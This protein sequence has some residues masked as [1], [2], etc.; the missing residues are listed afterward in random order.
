M[1]RHGDNDDDRLTTALQFQ[2][3]TPDV[4]R[5]ANRPRKTSRRR[6]SASRLHEADGVRSHAVVLENQLL[7]Q[8][9]VRDRDALLLDAKYVSLPVGHTLARANDR[10]AT[11]YF[12][13]CGVISLVSEMSTGHQVAVAA[14][15]A[16]GVIGLGPL[17][18]T[19]QYPHALVVLLESRGYRI[20]ADRFHSAFEHSEIL[21]HATL[22]HLGRRMR[23]LATAAACNRVHSHRQ[24]LARWL[25]DITDKAN[26]QSLPVTHETLAQMVGG[27]RHAVTVA[28][29]EL[30]KKGAIA[31]LRGRIDV[32]RRSVLIAQACECY[33]VPT[34]LGRS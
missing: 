16:E 25:L 10:V 9:P 30:R 23:E 20:S 33:G 7:L 22:E 31:H 5:H 13:D 4:T 34:E 2:C 24:R 28:L 3:A 18:G 21:R 19:P 6:P 12:P 1:Y 14:V 15:G 8:L 29:N 11:A 27:P 26:Q 32:L 17:F